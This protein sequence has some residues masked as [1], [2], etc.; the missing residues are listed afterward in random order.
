MRGVSTDSESRE[1]STVPKLTI[2]LALS[3]EGW[4]VYVDMFTLTRYFWSQLEA[5]RL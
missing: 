4:K 1:T 5:H 2:T 3:T